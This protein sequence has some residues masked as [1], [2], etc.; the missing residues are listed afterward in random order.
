MSPEAT[1]V[2]VRFWSDERSSQDGVSSHGQ[3]PEI[4]LP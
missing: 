1:T 3:I 4:G 2:F